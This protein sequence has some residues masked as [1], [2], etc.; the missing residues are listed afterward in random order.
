VTPEPADPCAPG[1]VAEVTAVRPRPVAPEQPPDFSF[2]Q[3]ASTQAALVA[4]C[5]RQADRIALLD[6]PFET[7]RGS[8]AR[9]RR[10]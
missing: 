5:E 8:A 7:A 3:M 1:A 4:L 10:P 9:A 2:E 6:P